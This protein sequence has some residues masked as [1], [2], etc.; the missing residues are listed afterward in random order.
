MLKRRV[1]CSVLLVIEIIAVNFLCSCGITRHL[2]SI[3]LRAEE[4]SQANITQFLEYIEARDI[5]SAK[6]MFSNEANQEIEDL[7]EQL[8]MI[9][10]LFPAG[11]EIKK[12]LRCSI[13]EG[14]DKDNDSYYCE[15]SGGCVISNGTNEY[16]FSYSEYIVDNKHPDRVGFFRMFISDASNDSDAFIVIKQKDYPK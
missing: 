11:I 1:I 3:S 13:G 12:M 14:W 6:A 10:D 9:I 2:H 8:Q 7:D 5:D 16:D 4:I 15:T